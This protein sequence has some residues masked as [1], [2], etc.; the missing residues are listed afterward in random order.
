MTDV[1]TPSDLVPLKEPLVEAVIEAYMAH[2][3]TEG[4]DFEFYEGGCSAGEFRY[5][6]PRFGRDTRAYVSYP[7]GQWK[8]DQWLECG[9]PNNYASGA[10]PL[11]LRASL[12]LGLAT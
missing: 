3:V 7:G 11:A 2:K 12:P 6:V 9:S 8:I 5:R 4:S 1:G 10:A